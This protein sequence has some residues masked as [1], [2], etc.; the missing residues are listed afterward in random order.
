MV[1]ENSNYD[2]CN[3]CSILIDRYRT[4][5]YLEYLDII[6]RIA[7]WHVDINLEL[8][9]LGLVLVPMK[10]SVIW[11]TLGNL[12]SQVLCFL[13]WKMSDRIECY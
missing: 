4:V 13:F 6:Y 9:G 8:E 10:P 1:P 3:N 7:S 2:A 12:I 5:Q 11:G